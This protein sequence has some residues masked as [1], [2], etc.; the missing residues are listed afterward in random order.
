MKFLHRLH[1]L[2][3]LT[4]LPSVQRTSHHEH[5][6]K[7]DIDGIKRMFLPISFCI[8]MMF[9][10]WTSFTAVRLQG[11]DVDVYDAYELVFMSAHSVPDFEKVHAGYMLHHKIWCRADTS[12][13]TLV[14]SLNFFPGSIC[15]KF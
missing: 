11:G 5:R 14:G 2:C 1:I 12:G 15:A 9:W 10:W 7:W 13:T 4:Q 3:I 6:Q 8:Y